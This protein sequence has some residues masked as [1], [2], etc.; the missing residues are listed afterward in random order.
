MPE[1]KLKLIKND[2]EKN[3]FIKDIQEAFQK[4]LVEKYGEWDKLV[5]PTEDIEESFNEEGAC[6]YFAVIDE[7]IVGGVIVSIDKE[8]QHNSLQLLYVKVGVQ[9]GG[10]GSNIWCSIEKL[11]PETIVWETHTPYYDKRNIHFYVNRLGFNIVEF[12]NEKHLDPNLKGETTG[13]MP[14]E[15]GKDFFRFEK[16]MK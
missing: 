14:E 7:K 1:L 2:E 6:A 3:I 13:G 15:V 12:F 11:Y 8:T 5:L 4:S 10:V 9:N 16:K